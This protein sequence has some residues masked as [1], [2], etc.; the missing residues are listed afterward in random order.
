MP[1]SPLS[2]TNPTRQTLNH[3]K[4]GRA[5]PLL[6]TGKKKKFNSSPI[7]SYAVSYTPQELVQP[8]HKQEEQPLGLYRWP[9]GQRSPSTSARDPNVFDP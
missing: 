3:E 7:F 9:Y 6:L 8:F 1:S 5:I 4:A 2:D